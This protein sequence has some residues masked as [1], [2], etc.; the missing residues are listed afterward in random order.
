[1]KLDD[2]PDMENNEPDLPDFTSKQGFLE[3]RS[4]MLQSLYKALEDEPNA[5]IIK[6]IRE[7]LADAD[8]EIIDRD[9]GISEALQ[10]LKNASDE[11]IAEKFIN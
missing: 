4:K 2:I 11:E 9:K 3:L 7:V 1:M 10:V 5:Q 8:V 6:Q